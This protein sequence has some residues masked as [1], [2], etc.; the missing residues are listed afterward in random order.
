MPMTAFMRD[1]G[2][3]MGTD[4]LHFD[5]AQFRKIRDVAEAVVNDHRA[6]NLTG[7][8]K[9]LDLSGDNDADYSGE[10]ILTALDVLNLLY[11]KEQ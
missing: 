10:Y 5:L 6:G 3:F 7:V 11:A 1:H 4:G 8:W 2:L 9:E